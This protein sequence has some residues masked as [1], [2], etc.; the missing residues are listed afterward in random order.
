MAQKIE[1]KKRNFLFKMVESR[2]G[3]KEATRASIGGSRSLHPNPRV[4]PKASPSPHG[5][6]LCPFDQGD[7]TRTQRHVNG[8]KLEI[9]GKRTWWSIGKHVKL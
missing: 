6:V 9:F 2:N 5:A 8:S 4:G 3:R 1:D 7:N